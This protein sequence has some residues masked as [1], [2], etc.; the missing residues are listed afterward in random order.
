ML[1]PYKHEPFTDFSIESNRKR[2]ESE[3]EKIERKLGGTY[4]LLIDGEKVLTEEKITSI[5]PGTKEEIIGSV[6]QAKPWAARC[7]EPG[8]AFRLSVRPQSRMA[9]QFHFYP[10]ARAT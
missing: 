6:A 2:L 8:K 9:K 5:T 4:D 10:M 3:L 1:T 7:L